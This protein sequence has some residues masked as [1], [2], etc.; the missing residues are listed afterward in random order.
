MKKR[1]YIASPY[2][3]GWQSQNVRRQLD[4]FDI[5][6]NN[7]FVPFAP[8]LDHFLEIYHHRP[9]KDW[10]DW[11]LE[12][13]K[14]CDIMVRIRPL[15]E[16]GEE[17]PSVGA[18]NEEKKANEWGIPVYT[19]KNLEELETWAKENIKYKRMKNDLIR[20]N[21]Y[22]SHTHKKTRLKERSRKKR[23]PPEQVNPYSVHKGNK[24]YEC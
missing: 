15:N 3:N 19:F 14:M 24:D 16:N 10:Y 5:L 22:D 18:D 8:L 11:D 17:I 13:L 7:G 20:I 1:V 12:W 23:I 4:A 21:P 9:E 6:F 2:S